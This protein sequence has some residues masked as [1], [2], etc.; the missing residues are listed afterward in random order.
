ML[1]SSFVCLFVCL[2]GVSVN[3]AQRNFKITLREEVRIRG[4]GKC[5][6]VVYTIG[7][8]VKTIYVTC[9]VVLY[10]RSYS[11]IKTN[12][13]DKINDGTWGVMVEQV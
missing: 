6:R 5:V 2:Y 13:F 8:M 4:S 10:S 9:H 1:T 12:F 7:E 3:T 11:T